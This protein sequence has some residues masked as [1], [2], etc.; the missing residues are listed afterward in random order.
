MTLDAAHRPAEAE[1]D[2]GPDLSLDRDGAGRLR[3]VTPFQA[4]AAALKAAVTVDLERLRK[5]AFQ[6][7]IYSERVK[8]LL[9][10]FTRAFCEREDDLSEDL[11]MA[12]FTVADCLRVL[13]ANLVDLE[14]EETAH[15]EAI[16]ARLHA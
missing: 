1:H 9:H 11:L 2:T 6:A 7:G 4:E 10:L 13:A 8:G 15:L 16:A 5:L 3:I 12:S 14:V